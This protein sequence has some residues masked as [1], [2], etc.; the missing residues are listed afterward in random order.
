M[1]SLL[2]SVCAHLALPRAA[3]P[4]SAEPGDLPSLPACCV[5]SGLSLPLPDPPS[6]HLHDELWS[7]KCGFKL[8]SQGRWVGTQSPPVTT[9]RVAL[10]SSEPGLWILKR[11]SEIE[12]PWVPKG[13]LR[14]RVKNPFAVP[15]CV[16]VVSL[17]GLGSPL[18]KVRACLPSQCL[19]PLWGRSGSFKAT[20]SRGWPGARATGHSPPR[21]T[22]TYRPLL[23]LGFL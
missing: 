2:P 5:T 10:C 4:T 1:R 16:A 14:A 12:E 15:S 21:P 13:T 17:R 20:W 19:G 8:V 18:C 11:G 23:T 9:R 7:S 3:G 6:P 22:T